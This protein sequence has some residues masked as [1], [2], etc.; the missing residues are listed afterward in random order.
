MFQKRK[1]KKKKTSI[2]YSRKLPAREAVKY[3][4]ISLVQALKAVT[5]SGLQTEFGGKIIHVEHFLC[6][7]QSWIIRWQ[8]IRRWIETVFLLRIFYRNQIAYRNH[9]IFRLTAK[10]IL[11]LNG[12]PICKSI[13]PKNIAIKMEIS[14]RMAWMRCKVNDQKRRIVSYRPIRVVAK[15]ERMIYAMLQPMR[16][17]SFNFDLKSVSVRNNGLLISY[18]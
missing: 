3:W 4:T 11:R 17:V 1:K 7:R 8:I 14:K 18:S 16:T 10:I 12:K 2:S 9:H 15:T 13:M 5:S 6:K